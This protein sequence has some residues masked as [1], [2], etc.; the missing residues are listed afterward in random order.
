MNGTTRWSQRNS[1]E[2][3]AD[4]TAAAAATNHDPRHTTQKNEEQRRDMRAPTG[5]HMTPHSDHWHH[6]ERRRLTVRVETVTRRNF[7]AIKRSVITNTSNAC[8]HHSFVVRTFSID[9]NVVAISALL[10]FCLLLVS[11][12]V[13]IAFARRSLEAGFAWSCGAAS[14]ATSVLARARAGNAAQSPSAQA[15]NQ[16]L[17][18]RVCNVFVVF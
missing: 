8:Q 7:C 12:E 15:D 10:A 16:S 14:P 11:P 17:E 6:C 18:E 5:P 9:G 3:G 1:A 2:A 13:R 4:T